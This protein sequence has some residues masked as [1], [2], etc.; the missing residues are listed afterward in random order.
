M[1]NR[2]MDEATRE[3]VLGLLD[4]LDRLERKLPRTR[5][6]SRSRGSASWRREVK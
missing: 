3:A 2:L 4:R 5:V 1:R 6:R